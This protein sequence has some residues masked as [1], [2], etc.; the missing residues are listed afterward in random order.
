[1]EKYSKYFIIG[2]VIPSFVIF[3]AVPPNHA[4]ATLYGYFYTVSLEGLNLTTYST[5]GQVLVFSFWDPLVILNPKN[6]FY[7]HNAVISLKISNSLLANTWNTEIFLKSIGGE[8]FILALIFAIVGLIVNIYVTK[9]TNSLFITETLDEAINNPYSKIILFF[10]FMAVLICQ[11]ISIS[12]ALVENDNFSKSA[13]LVPIGLFFVLY[14]TMAVL[15]TLEDNYLFVMKYVTRVVGII[16]V[17]LIGI[18]IILGNSIITDNILSKI[19]NFSD[20]S[21]MDQN[22]FFK[23]GFLVFLLFYM[24][25]LYQ[26]IIEMRQLKEQN[27]NIARSLTKQFLSPITHLIDKYITGGSM[28]PETDELT[29]EN[30]RFQNV[31][32]LV[33]FLIKLVIFLIGFYIVYTFLSYSITDALVLNITSLFLVLLAFSFVNMNKYS[34][35]GRMKIMLNLTTIISIFYISELMEL[36]IHHVF[37]I[38]RLTFP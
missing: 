25:L 3:F 8:F 12:L 32:P 15:F 26:N 17:I 6:G 29:P 23:T 11:L 9:R 24:W 37:P 22:I 31:P 16:L 5:L 2:M 30:Q 10:T 4:F 36:I 27:R 18:V 21:G 28:N 13:L 7:P 1:M 20:L 34:Y 19:I 33:M 38:V 35:E 14:A